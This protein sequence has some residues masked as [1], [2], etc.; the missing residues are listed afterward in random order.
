MEIFRGKKP[1]RGRRAQEHQRRDS[2]R[3]RSSSYPLDELVGEEQL[4]THTSTGTR[5]KTK[6]DS[7][8]PAISLGH[9][10]FLLAGL[11]LGASLFVGVTVLMKWR[12]AL[13][14]R[15]LAGQ[16]A[17]AQASATPQGSASA[18]PA[19]PKTAYQATSPVDAVR[20]MLKASYAGDRDTAYAQ[21]DIGPHEMATLV[22]GQSVTL[23]EM[24]AKAGEYGR[25]VR[26]DEF[27]FVHTRQEG[28][29]AVVVQ[30]RAGTVV[31]VYSLH[32]HGPYWKIRFA[33]RP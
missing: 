9:V 1:R 14:E 18:Q 28:D 23:A 16:K 19:A 3:K 24:T 27:Q 13:N 20:T 6:R 32:R 29:R 4:A 30:K 22:S 31:Q 25:S 2:R 12:H 5:R 11:V 7:T 15:A 8:L 21:W 33:S 17:E 26:L 10:A